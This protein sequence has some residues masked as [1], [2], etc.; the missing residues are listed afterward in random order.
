MDKKTDVTEKKTPLI[1]KDKKEKNLYSALKLPSIFKKAYTEKKFNKKI[2][3]KIYLPKDKE[4][5]KAMFKKGNNKDKPELLSIDLT[6]KYTK[7]ELLRFKTLAKE[8]KGQKGR[9]KLLPLIATAASM[10]AIVLTVLTFKNIIV[11]NAIVSACESVFEAKTDIDS[12]KVEILGAQVKINGLAVGNKKSYYRNLFEIKTIDF[13]FNL[14]QIL[15]GKFVCE[16]L[17]CSGMAF[18][19]KRKTSCYI[20]PKVKSTEESAFTKALKEKT[21]TALLDLK[22]QAAQLVGGED[23][24][25]IVENFTS[26]LKTPEAAKNAESMA[27]QLSGKW[28]KK[29]S[30]LKSEIDL[31]TSEINSKI[32]SLSSV[33]KNDPASVIK[34]I[35]TID[36]LLKE[37]DEKNQNGIKYKITQ[38]QK[39]VASDFNNLKTLSS[40]LTQAVS[41]DSDFVKNR[42]STLIGTVANPKAFLSQA[43]NTVGYDYL[44]NYY[45]YA[46]KLVDY[47]LEVRK[48]AIAEKNKKEEEERFKKIEKEE[49]STVSR[50]E[51]RTF[52]YS[53]EYPA[54]L[55]ERVYVSGPAFEAKLLEVASNPDIRNKPCEFTASYSYYGV[56]HDAA[57]VVDARSESSK[58]LVS[59]DYKGSGFKAS[60][61]GQK[62]AS[63]NGIPSIDGKMSLNFRGTADSDGFTVGGKVDLNPVTLSSDG[64]ENERASKYYNMALAAVTDLSMDCTMGYKSKDG[65]IFDINGNFA[66]QFEKG[67]KAAAYGVA[68][69]VTGEVIKRLN[70]KINSSSGTALVKVKEVLGIEGEVNVQSLRLDNLEKTLETKKKEFSANTEKAVENAVENAKKEAAGAIIKGLTGSDPYKTDT[71]SKKKDLKKFF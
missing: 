55:I 35:E 13:D 62:I 63:K 15:R 49:K 1:K 20:K 47:A 67:L 18:N 24:D 22:A 68:G 57:L 36:S 48:N 38:V 30:E 34:A 59:A 53:Q 39:D 26:Q 23:V 31:K 29:P 50:S 51:G 4:D 61:N 25:S 8:I 33:N 40:D 64:F 44:G 56:K 41:H 7:V 52:W 71:A 32:K 19:T 21:N 37:F 43:L 6:A 60:F 14:T 16:N 69:D 66:S 2:L 65:V 3:K 9:I 27:L 58:P 11:K 46:Q 28:Q 5:I 12:V 45:P 42:V 54:F 10:F 17:E 70:E